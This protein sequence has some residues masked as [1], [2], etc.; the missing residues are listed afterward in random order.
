VQE[1]DTVVEMIYINLQLHQINLKHIL[2]ATIKIKRLMK[3]QEKQLMNYLP[4]VQKVEKQHTTIHS[5][6][7]MIQHGMVEKYLKTVEI[8]I[9]THGNKNK[10]QKTINT[11]SF[12]LAKNKI[13]FY[14]FIKGR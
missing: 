13:F 11:Y 10:N 9:K 2:Q 8:D 3:N 14:N 6:N 12:F 5:S 7:R 4:L 1:A